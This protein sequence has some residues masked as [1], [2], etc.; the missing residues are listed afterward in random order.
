MLLMAHRSDIHG[1]VS[2]SEGRDVGFG[3]ETHVQTLLCTPAALFNTCMYV[4]LHIYNIL[5]ILQPFHTDAGEENGLNSVQE[6]I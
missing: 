2:S 6:K 5:P 3:L 1:T 4:S